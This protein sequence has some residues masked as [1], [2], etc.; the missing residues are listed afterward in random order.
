MWLQ[1]FWVDKGNVRQ[2]D[3]KDLPPTSDLIASP[4]DADARLGTTRDTRWTG[5]KLHVTETCDEHKINLI[6]QVETAQP[7]RHDNQ[8]V[9]AIHEALKDKQLLPKAHIVDMAFRDSELM[10]NSQ[11]DY[12]VSLDGKMRLNHNWRTKTQGAYL[13]DDFMIDW[14]AE[15]VTCP[16]GKRGTYWYEG[17]D[18]KGNHPQIQVLTRKIA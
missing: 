6:T 1:Q 14:E 3:A 16:A 9:P 10:V 11:H 2:Q 17:L 5:Y 7:N 4:Y 15:Q 12:G 18:R 13:I 8:Q